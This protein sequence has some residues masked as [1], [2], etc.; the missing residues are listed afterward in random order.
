MKTTNKMMKTFYY[1]FIDPLFFNPIQ[2]NVKECP[3]INDLKKKIATFLNIDY[4]HLTV[5]NQPK[6]KFLEKITENFVFII[7]FPHRR[8]NITFFLPISKTIHIE[9]G[10]KMKY[11]EIIDSFKQNQLYYS[12][13]CI[14]SHV[15]FKIFDKEL[16][17]IEYPFLAIPA[18]ICINVKMNCETVILKYGNKNFVFSE[19]EFV[20]EAYKLIKETYEGCHSVTIQK[21]EGK[22]NE[23]D[24]LKKFTSY[25]VK[26]IFKVTFK[27]IENWNE[28]DIFLDF[29]STVSDAQKQLYNKNENSNIS[30]INIYNGNM[31]IIKDYNQMLKNIQ[32]F[33]NFFY[34]E[35][36]KR[37]KEKVVNK[38]LIVDLDPKFV[39]TPK[40]PNNQV[41]YEYPKTPEIKQKTQIKQK[42]A[43]NSKTPEKKSKPLLEQKPSVKS[44]SPAKKTNSNLKEFNS[45]NSEKNS[46]SNSN[47]NS[48]SKINKKESDKVNSKSKP[49][50]S[51]EE[52]NFDDY[53][54]YFEMNSKKDQPKESS[55]D[56]FK[57]NEL[58]DLISDEKEEEEE[59]FEA[60][61]KNQKNT[62]DQK[63]DE[64]FEEE[65]EELLDNASVKTHINEEEEDK[66]GNSLNDD[67]F[68]FDDND[69]ASSNSNQEENEIMK[70]FE[71]DEAE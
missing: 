7:K 57:L 40:K 4:Y 17:H 42:V 39:F 38:K 55:D 8:T 44:K 10:H 2:V 27:N 23:S 22:L 67:V 24:K 34:Y 58:K 59:E 41:N 60:E 12:D 30:K 70:I 52:D 9:N 3:T 64:N 48:K 56:S 25:E 11:D 37:P 13:K 1:Q 63:S 28:D 19:N 66:R 18:G 71:E 32:N 68:A 35:V 29:M 50:K 20:S 46:E 5:E 43:I 33:E 21:N 47:N 53:D 15:L 6:E 65:E 62:A 16:P 51:K 49:N 36:I 61:N 54:D 26:V 31:Q 69:N 45:K 14:K